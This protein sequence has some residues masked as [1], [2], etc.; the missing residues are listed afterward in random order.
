[1]STS[2]DNVANL[3][4]SDSGMKNHALISMKKSSS[5]WI[6]DSGASKH[7][8]GEFASYTPYPHSF[9][10]TIQTAD[11][12]SQPIRGVG[13]VK[14]T[15]AITLSSVLYVPSFP[16]NLVSISSLVDQMDCR[17]SLDHE[18]YLIQER[19]TGKRLGTRVQHNGLW[20]L[21]RRKTDEAICLALSAV[22]SEEEAKVMLLHY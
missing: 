5:S 7:V 14:C 11:G 9:K 13:T 10:E 15:P 22:A 20:Y 12:T 1:M 6:L 8:T 4:H 21:D 16:V 3:V 19:K 2:T 18:N 17:V